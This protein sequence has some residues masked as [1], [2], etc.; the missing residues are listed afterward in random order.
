M[1]ISRIIK[2]G[3][4]CIASVPL[5][6]QP[7]IFQLELILL[8][9]RILAEHQHLFA[10]HGCYSNVK[11]KECGKEVTKNVTPLPDNFKPLKIT[12]AMDKAWLDIIRDI[13]LP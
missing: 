3:A 5:S 9:L 13:P 1:N 8:P 2:R 7:C 12:E 11:G 4:I 10:E 6:A